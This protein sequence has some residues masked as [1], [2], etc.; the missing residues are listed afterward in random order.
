MLRRRAFSRLPPS[1]PSPVPGETLQKNRDGTLEAAVT[2]VRLTR[3]SL[4]RR[5][6]SFAAI[7]P[8]C[9][10]YPLSKKFSFL[11]P[12]GPPRVARARAQLYFRLKSED[13]ARIDGKSILAPAKNIHFTPNSAINPPRI[14]PTAIPILNT[15]LYTALAEPRLA[16]P[17]ISLT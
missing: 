4:C 9:S 8:K 16:F 10:N 12:P 15:T 14:F 7:L 13:V 11:D 5:M 3:Q 6:V 2:R 1:V 17:E